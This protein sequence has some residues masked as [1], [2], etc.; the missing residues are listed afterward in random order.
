MRCFLAI[1]LPTDVR[2]Q[3]AALQEELRATVRS[4][5][6]TR[7][8]QIHLTLKFLGDV[9]D[10]EVAGVC[11]AVGETAKACPPFELE[12]GGAGCFPGGG[13]VRVV[14]AGIARPAAELA[15]CQQGCEARLAELGFKPEGRPYTPH[16]TIGRLNDFRDSARVR[17]EVEAQA[18][19][20]AGRLTVT[21]LTLFESVL[22]PTGAEHHVI[23]R[24]RLGGQ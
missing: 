24:A 4:V 7:P 6:W 8:E 15:A 1:E 14:W 11:A 18:A 5:R 2:D 17:S 20:H 22:R 21:E 9:P 16:L 10:A 3:I 23:S 13:P 12:I 19:F